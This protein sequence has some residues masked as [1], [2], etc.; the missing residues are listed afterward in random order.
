MSRLVELLNLTKLKGLGGS[1]SW[2]KIVRDLERKVRSLEKENEKLQE[3]LRLMVDSTLPKMN[4]LKERIDEIDIGGSYGEA[5][6]EEADRP[7]VK[8]G[9][10]RPRK[11]Q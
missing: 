5:I 8:R 1:M 2:E 7:V 4:D 3:A 11:S 9:R 10:G 6:R